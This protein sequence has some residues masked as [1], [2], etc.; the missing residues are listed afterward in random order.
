MSKVKKIVIT[1][2]VILVI[3][4]SV[5]IFYVVKMNNRELRFIIDGQPTTLAFNVKD[6]DYSYNLIQSPKYSKEKVNNYIEENFAEIKN[7]QELVNKINTDLES[8]KYISDL[9]MQGIVTQQELQKIAYNNKMKNL[10]ITILQKD[11][12]GLDDINIK[13]SDLMDYIDDVYILSE[14][15]CL[16]F[17]K[18]ITSQYEGVERDF[19][20]HNGEF[21]K[22]PYCKETSFG[23]VVNTKELSQLLI[24]AINTETTQIEIP[25]KREGRKFEQTT[26]GV[27]NDIGNKYIEISIQDQHLWV[28]DNNDVLFDCDVVTG[29]NGMSTPC[30]AFDIMEKTQN[31]HMKGSYGTAFAEYWLR[32]TNSG[33]GIHAA[34]WRGSFGGT[35]Y[36]NSGS[37]G[38]INV[39]VASSK[40]LYE[41]VERKTPTVIY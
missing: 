3:L 38:C 31:E 21:V 14:D 20:N 37:H 24:D 41:N 10:N 40:W 22:V 30:G 34:N 2:G 36:K 32:L 27:F 5:L 25:F 18:M 4:V 15:K 1:I 17:A 12:T 28:W 23:W 8:R 19:I 35:I 6:M 16:D 33:I 7:K 39:S 11:K 29:K 26:K 13:A 9:D